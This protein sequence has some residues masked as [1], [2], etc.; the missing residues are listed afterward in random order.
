[1]KKNIILFSIDGVRP[2]LIFNSEKY[3]IELPNIKSIIANGVST[4]EGMQVVFPALT[5]TCHASMMTG[6]YPRTHAISS[7]MIW[8]PENINNGCWNWFKTEKTDNL[9]DLAHK[10]GYFV[11]NV[12]FPGAVGIKADYNF[13]E[14]WGNK[15][16]LDHKFM[17]SMSTPVGIVEEFEKKFGE[18]PCWERDYASD[19]KRF[20]AGMWLCENKIK[21]I[22]D[23]KP[24]FMTQYFVS[25]DCCAHHSGIFSKE[26]FT[27]LENFDLKIGEM[28][29]YLKKI[30]NNNLIIN[31]VSDH[32]FI[33]V[34]KIFRLN[35]V[36]KKEGLLQTN[37]SGKLISYDAISLNRDGTTEIRLKNRKNLVIKN[38]VFSILKKIKSKYPNIIDKLYTRKDLDRLMASKEADFALN[39]KSGFRFCD[40]F[41]GDI[42]I[43]TVKPGDYWGTYIGM[44][45]FSPENTE[46]NSCY[47]ISGPGIKK[48]T[49]ISGVKIVDV[50]PTLAAI[51]GIK[52]K[53]AEG[54][55]LDVI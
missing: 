42:I 41:D 32:G 11:V 13:I 8:D 35:T 23:E 3:G 22:V 7:N 54:K 26:A 27:V 14:Y 9:W 40:D 29:K 31:I 44:H 30:T 38:K 36:F 45:G 5:Y 52:M 48:N 51:M 34:Q 50:A 39:A 10:E 1:M 17:S 19:E 12:G 15:T 28:I 43:D 47:I 20:A 55:Y 46:M 25:Y 18:Y 33:P 53:S 6:T 2:E 4:K 16:R 21:P 37:G 24:F 49:F